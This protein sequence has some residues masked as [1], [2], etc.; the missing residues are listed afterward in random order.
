MKANILTLCDFAKE[1]NGQLTIVGTFNMIR[2]NVFPT[3]PLKFFLVCQFELKDNIVG[4]HHVTVSIKNKDTGEFLIKEQ[5]FKLNIVKHSSDDDFGTMYTNLLLDFDKVMFQSPS[6]YTVD[7]VSD[8][9][10][11]VIEFKVVKS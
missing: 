10:H 4:D 1:Y 9:N 11:S 2:S 5:E 3:I 6:V 7:V 8:G